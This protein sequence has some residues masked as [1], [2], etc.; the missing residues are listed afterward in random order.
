MVIG[1]R[2]WGRG[3]LERWRDEELERWRVAGME[4]WGGFPPLQFSSSPIRP[5]E[6]RPFW[7]A[8][9]VVELEGWRNREVVN[10]FTFPHFSNFPL[11][12]IPKDLLLR[13]ATCTYVQ[14]LGA[15]DRYIVISSM[16]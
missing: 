3:E 15:S 10:F 7:G 9:R 1:S 2:I 5:W 8:W 12:H 13:A 4:G 14:G 16:I 11:A 6:L